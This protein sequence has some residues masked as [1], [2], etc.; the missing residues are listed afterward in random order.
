MPRRAITMRR[1]STHPQQHLGASVPVES[2]TLPSRRK[3]VRS[4]QAAN[5]GSCVTSTPE[6]PR[7]T[8]PQHASPL[9]G[10]RVECAGGLVGE[11][12][13]RGPTSAPAIATRCC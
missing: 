13:R 12:S 2:I 4:A 9:A 11:Q 8:S 3:T 5:R 6:A 1:A 7:R 10:D